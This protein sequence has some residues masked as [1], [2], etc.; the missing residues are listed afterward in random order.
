MTQHCEHCG[1]DATQIRQL[2]V[3]S[4]RMRDALKNQPVLTDH[5]QALVDAYE[6]FTDGFEIPGDAA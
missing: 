3:F 5:E 1:A 2:V 6:S 4:E